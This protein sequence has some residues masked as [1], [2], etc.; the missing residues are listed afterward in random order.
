MCLPGAL[1]AS[2]ATAGEALSA[3]RAG[4]SYL[5]AADLASL[6]SAEQADCLLALERAES[7]HTA[8][9]ARVLTA[10]HAQGGY[11]DDGHGSAR[12]WL[13]WR[14]QIS[15][16]AAADALRWMRLLSAHP[17]VGVALAA[18]EISESFARQICAWTDLLPQDCRGHA[19]RILLGAAVA[20]AQ[21][22]KLGELAEEMRRRTARPDSD[23][24][25]FDDR[26]LYLGR[27]FGGAGTVRGDLTPPCAAALAAV[28]EALGKRA[29]PE[30]L[31][32]KWQRQ[33]D[34]LEEAMRRLIAAGGLPERGGQPTQIV[35]HLGLDQLR[36][37]LGASAAETAWVGAAAGPGYDCDATMVPVVTG[38][39][40]TQ[41]LDR[42]AAWL[43]YGH[44]GQ[45]GCG[46]RARSSQPG[47]AG[48]AGQPSQAGQASHDSNGQTSPDGKT[49]GHAGH[50]EHASQGEDS[51][52]AAARRRLVED[53]VRQI[54]IDRAADLLS[55]PGGL[56]AWLR[57]GLLDG[58]AASVS[59]PLDVGAATETIPA[60]LRR[61][62]I[63][64]DRCCRFPGCDQPPAG[65]Q[66]HHIIPRSQS[67]PTSLTNLLLLC[68]FHHLIAVHRWGWDIVLLPDGT[69]T[70]TSPDRSRTLRSHGPPSRAA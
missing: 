17:E 37:L 70:A 13:R 54:L 63:V 42:L 48:Q 7:M 1:P 38:R 34:A 62:V 31:R 25:G 44:D 32:S 66:P 5:N 11:R 57:T 26:G 47:R 60:H 68:S 51:E 18:A 27:T 4:F 8:A 49:A 23:D 64:R 50:G 59:L 2:P 28:L 33:H 45:A 39:V 67:G 46:G 35:L 53:A 24:D 9:R 14:A 41:V 40:D 10:F 36:G 61:A 52:A 20:G 43:L 30:D 15:S 29:G 3:I 56:A 12:A 6:T 22:R 21:L 65:C 58:P 19:D 55:G 69:V 16:G